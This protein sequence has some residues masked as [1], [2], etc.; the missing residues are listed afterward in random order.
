MYPVESSALYPLAEHAPVVAVV[1][2][3]AP[4]GFGTT[5][6]KANTAR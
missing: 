2:I 3:P 4:M 1:G 5:V 6:I